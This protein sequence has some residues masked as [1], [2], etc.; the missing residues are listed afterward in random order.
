MT[1]SLRRWIQVATRSKPRGRSA[2]LFA[3]GFALAAGL[4]TLATFFAVSGAGPIGPA[5]NVMLGLVLMSLALIVL[6]A[7]VLTL[8]IV[9]IAGARATP[10]A[11]ARLHLRFVSLFSLAAVAP[12]ILVALFLGTTMSRGVEQWFSHRVESVVENG[13]DVGRSV[14]EAATESIR[15]EILAMATDLNRAEDGLK[16]DAAGYRDYLAKQ[17]SFRGFPSAHVIDRSGRV[18]AQ[19]SSG[20]GAPPY[21]APSGQAFAAADAGDVSMRT[22]ETTDVI[23]A[24]YKLTAYPDAYLYV[25]RTLDAGILARLRAFE[26]SVTDYRETEQRR[27]RLQTLFALSYL[28]TALLVLLGAVWVGLENASRVAEPIGKLAEAARRVAAGDLSARVEVRRERDEVD[29]LARAFN[30]MT[31]QIEAQRGELVRE[32]QDAEQSTR[33]IEAVLSGVSAG[34]LGLDHDGRVRAAN[35]SAAALLGVE[36]GTL[37]GRRLLDVAPEFSDLLALA[38]SVSGDQGQ[39]RVDLVRAGRTANL[40]VRVSVDSGGAGLVLTFDDMT[41]LIAAQRQ[42]AW[43]D[44]ARRIAHEIRNPLTPIQLSA[45][46][47]RRKYTAEVKSDPE[48]FARC[49]ETILRQVADIGRMVEE[50]S[51]FARMPVPR[52][53]RENLTEIVRDAL[54]AQRLAHSDTRFELEAPPEPVCADCDGRL[55]AQALANLLKNAGEAIQ[56]RRARDGEPKEGLVRIAL[57]ETEA[58][59][60]MEIAD[61]GIGLPALERARLTEPYVTTRAKGTGLGLAIVHRVAEDHGGNLELD[62]APDGGPGALVRLTLAKTVATKTNSDK[63]GPAKLARAGKAEGRA[64]E[65]ETGR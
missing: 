18:L 29:A 1:T 5:S 53:A 13:A 64:R 31:R 22:Y 20:S 58:A 25:A 50:F 52:M 47:L 33:F 34:V 35:R 2:A 19:A 51:A 59:V 55:V 63:A 14:V 32:R 7:G 10:D 15:G 12:A 60:G 45:E 30:G 39:R 24:L 17:A 37:V 23:R 8:K 61:N 62:D 4:T 38:P 65:P 28:A 3:V 54:F 9:R 56:A 57:W 42:E 41:D 6:L 44:V 36:E 49:T 46:R 27:G 40:S 43:K 21:A 48:T 26:Q 16:A 11:G